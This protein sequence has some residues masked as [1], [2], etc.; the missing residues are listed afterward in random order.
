MVFPAMASAPIQNVTPVIRILPSS[1]PIFRISSSSCI[2]CITLPAA[3]NIKPLKN[4]CVNRWKI[5]AVY[6][7][8]P[9]PMNMYPNWLTVE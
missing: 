4:A 2:A 7:P 5:P 9:T 1:P 3:R 6:A 8:T